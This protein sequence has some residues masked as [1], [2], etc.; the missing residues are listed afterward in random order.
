MPRNI[1]WDESV[2]DNALT[3]IE[4]LLQLSEQQSENLQ[5]KPQLYVDWEADKLRVTGYTTKLTSGRIARTVEVG[6]KKEHLLNCVKAVNKSLKLPQRKRESGSNH[7]ERELQ[8]IQYVFDS[9]RELGL[10]AEDSNKTRKNQGYWKF[11]LTLKHQTASKQEN[12]GVVKQKWNEHPKTNSSATSKI[13]QTT[14]KSIDWREICYKMLEAQQESAKLRRKATEKGFEINVHILLGLVERKHQQRRGEHENRE[15]ETVYEL[16]KEVIVKNYEHDTFL[17]EVIGQKPA[18]NHKHIAIIGEPGAGKTTLLS[19]IASFIKSKTEDLTI[20]ISL[21]NL[22]EKTIEDYLLKIWLPQAIRLG[23]PNVVVTPEIENQLIERFSKGGVWLLLDGVDE[24]GES[25]AIQSLT[26]IN[27]ELTEWLRQARVVLTCCL[28]VWDINVNNKLTG[29]DT[30]KTQEFQSDQIDDFIQQWF[31][32]AEQQQRGE[33]LKVKLKETKHKKIRSLVKNPLRLALL[34]QTFDI[35][36]G[37]LPET[38]AALYQRYLR[39]FYEWKS[40]HIR[41]LINSDELKNELHQALSKLAFAGINSAA[42]FRLKR[43]LAQQEMGEQLFNLACDVGW[44]NLVDRLAGSDEEVYAFFHP[45]FQE[46]FAA[47]AIP[48]WHFFLRHNNKIELPDYKSFGTL[49]NPSNYDYFAGQEIGTWT[50]LPNCNKK[51]YNYCLENNQ[52]DCVYRIFEPQWQEVILL[53]LGREINKDFIKSKE[54]FIKLLVEFNDNCLGFYSFRAYFLA[55]MGIVEF[56]NCT[57][58]N[59]NDIVAQL[60]EWSLGHS[61]DNPICKAAMAILPQFDYVRLSKYLDDIEKSFEDNLDDELSLMKREAMNSIYFTLFCDNCDEHGQDNSNLNS[62][63][64]SIE[65]ENIYPNVITNFGEI[66]DE[67]DTLISLLYSSQNRTIILRSALDLIDVL[68]DGLLMRKVV[69]ALRDCL[70]IDQFVAIPSHGEPFA[71][72]EN[73]FYCFKCC[74]LVLWHCAQNMSYPDFYNAWYQGSYEDDNI[75]GKETLNQINFIQSLQAT[76]KQDTQ[77]SQTIQLIGID[78][79]NFIDLDNPAVEIYA[80]MVAQGCPERTTGEPATMQALKV[81]CKL[82]KSDKRVV[83]VF[84][85][86]MGL[87]LQQLSDRFLNDLSK[88]DGSICVISN[89]IIENFPLKFFTPSQSIDNVILWLR[90]L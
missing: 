74:Y 53:W 80:E 44:L 70:S 25:S 48:D 49:F 42:R 51:L 31:T 19:N 58:T 60:F 65:H 87:Q 34:C 40:E 72:Y 57:C 82:L 20:F 12:L 10:L 50:N 37:E 26:K 67:I 38:K 61:D 15:L 3:L 59:S 85:Q 56:K 29:F 8:E 88:F 41:E 24:M 75:E 73:Q 23:K 2:L 77:I 64:Y 5:P 76:I 14:D 63:D 33:E 45:N 89:Q 66:N 84:Y 39:Y 54:E 71:S 11:T 35:D 21:A 69:I 30:Y 83:L 78:T 36:Q 43:S 86:G 6:T 18:G 13:T 68:T 81:Y 9:L 55:A 17:Q 46:Y 16:E 22:Q 28:N 52:K 27:Q 90:T 62:S 4:A 79:S 1:R 47:L 32:C 7:S